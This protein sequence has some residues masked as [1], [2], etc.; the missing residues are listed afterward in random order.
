MHDEPTVPEVVASGV[1]LVT[2]SGDKLLGGPQAGILVGKAAVMERVRR[3]PLHRAV[4]VDKFTIAALEAT[5]KLYADPQL[6]QRQIPTLAMLSLTPQ[7]IGQRIRRLRR[8]LPAAVV[9]A[10]RMH[11]I[12]GTSAVGGGALPLADLPTRLVALQPTF[13]SLSELERQLRCRRPA[14]IGR[15]AHDHYLLDFRTVQEHEIAEIATALTQLVPA[16]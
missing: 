16:V 5:L 10:Y 9:E 3:H 7:A 11:T 1:D 14:I 2:F 12:D 15:I 4:R 8:R 13:C 6:A